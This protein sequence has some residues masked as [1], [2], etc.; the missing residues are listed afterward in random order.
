MNKLLMFALKKPASDPP[1]NLEA[2]PCRPMKVNG[3]DSS[4]RGYRRRPLPRCL[5]RPTF[6]ISPRA[7]EFSRVSADRSLPIQ[8][9]RLVR[10]DIGHSIGVSL[11]REE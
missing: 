11:P 4:N 2:A 5:A 6:A 10:T 7:G 1:E 9:V 3:I 8:E